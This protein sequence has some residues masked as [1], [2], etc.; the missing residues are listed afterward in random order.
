MQEFM[1]KPI[2]LVFVAIYFII[3]IGMG[4]YSS[5]EAK[6]SEDFILAGKGLGPVILVG[7]FL[8][9]Y[10]G[11]GTISGG[12]NSLSYTYGLW[13]GI[14]FFVP[15][16]GAILVL[17]I[18]SGKVREAGVYTL[19]ELLQ[20][21]YG[22]FA[23]VLSGG[24]IA[25]A[26]IS[27][28]AY[29]YK[30]LAYVLNVTTGMDMKIGVVIAAVM[31]IFLACSGGLKSVAITDAFSAFVMLFGIVLATPFVMKA[32]GGW[33]SVIESA[34]IENP[35]SL[36]F[37]GGQTFYGFLAGYFPLFFMTCGDQNMYQRVIAGKN[38]KT[39]RFGFFGWFL[40]V[41]IVMPLVA[42]IAFCAKHIFGT[43]IEAGMA[44]MSTTT[45]IPTAI[46]GLLLAASTAFIVTTGDSYLLS[47]ATNITYDIY[48]TKINPN[49]TDSQK[50][51]LTKFVIV[52]AGIFAYVLIQ[53]FPSVLAIQYW[54]YTINGAGITPAL[55]AALCW[56][57]VTKSGGIASMFVGTFATIIWEILGHPF[58][59]AT[60]LVAVPV[61][62]LTLIVVSLLTQKENENETAIEAKMNAGLNANA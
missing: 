53:F 31:I 3:L 42:I 10:V 57:K 60:I 48:A 58:G 22:D 34:K 55:L 49:A 51:K 38:N 14:F 5:K 18:L 15:A 36:T 26:M 20:K 52:A 25:L 45:V 27:I 28:C 50:L 44:F 6:N 46:G 32:A 8:A 43:N 12:G 47:G 21:K 33:G 13:P 39:M 62:F 41:L 17:F 54:S 23:H 2:L 9:T 35:Q 30:G 29:Q 59:L 56:K 40:G 16:L 1:S 37:S 4:I 24:I 61:S 7:T 19:A 11:N